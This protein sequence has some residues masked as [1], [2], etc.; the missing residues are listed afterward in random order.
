MQEEVGQ[1][2]PISADLPPLAFG[3]EQARTRQPSSNKFTA[4]PVKTLA[5]E[6]EPVRQPK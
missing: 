4:L 6:A 5:D 2:R 3:M 1:E